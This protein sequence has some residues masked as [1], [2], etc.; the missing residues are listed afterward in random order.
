MDGEAPPALP[1]ERLVRTLTNPEDPADPN[2]EVVTDVDSLAEH[3]AEDL[4]QA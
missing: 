1:H 2:V 4:A 3:M